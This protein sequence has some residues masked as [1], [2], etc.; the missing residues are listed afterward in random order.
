[1][2]EIQQASGTLLR[3]RAALELRG[4][5]SIKI[6]VIVG[7]REGA[8]LTRAAQGIEAVVSTLV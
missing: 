3:E 8:Y 2:N 7:G 4:R 6:L 1:M 5:I